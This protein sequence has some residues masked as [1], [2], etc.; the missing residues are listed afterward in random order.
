MNNYS[1]KNLKIVLN[2]DQIRLEMERV[3]IINIINNNK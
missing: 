1:K 2:K 3:E